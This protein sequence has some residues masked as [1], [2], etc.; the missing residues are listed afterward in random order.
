MPVNDLLSKISQT[1]KALKMNN[2]VHLSKTSDNYRYYKAICGMYEAGASFGRGKK[3]HPYSRGRP[4]F[5][6]G[7]GYPSFVPV[8]PSKSSRPDYPDDGELPSLPPS[9]DDTEAA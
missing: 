6:D 4:S 2:W 7:F 8:P 3:K 9:W 1:K 5:F